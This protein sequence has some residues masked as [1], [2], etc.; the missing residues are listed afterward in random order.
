MPGLTSMATKDLRLDHG[1]PALSLSCW[2]QTFHV[3]TRSLASLSS[4]CAVPSTGNSSTPHASTQAAGRAMAEPPFRRR[5]AIIG[6]GEDMKR[7]IEALMRREDLDGRAMREA[8]TLIVEGR[9]ASEQ[10]AAFLCLLHAK[11]ETAEEVSTLVEVRVRRAR[12]GAAGNCARWAEHSGRIV[13]R[14]LA[15]P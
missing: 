15:R 5:L 8:A 13:T 11:T 1:C 14:G 12:R 9:A 2:S 10:V 3:R 6:D 4:L 7:A